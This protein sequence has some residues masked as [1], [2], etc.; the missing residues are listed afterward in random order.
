MPDKAKGPELTIVNPESR[1]RPRGF[2][3]GVIAPAGWR[4]LYVA[5]QTAAG[6][7]G[8]ITVAEFAAQFD[9]ALAKVVDVVRSA[10]GESR[11]ITRLTIYVTDMDAYLAS[12]AALGS[13]WRERMGSHY[14][15]MALLGVQVLVDRGAM[16]EIEADAALPPEGSA[17]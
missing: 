4:T 10:G 8:R 9:T 16:V 1:P 7:D 14:P 6:D 5:G 11:H 2:A 17:R 3:H 15:A 12:R 13:I